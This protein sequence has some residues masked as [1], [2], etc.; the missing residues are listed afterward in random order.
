LKE[1]WGLGGKGHGGVLLRKQ[2]HNVKPT[3]TPVGKGGI[4]TGNRPQGEEFGDTS[5]KKRHVHVEGKKTSTHTSA[6]QLQVTPLGVSPH[7]KKRT[8]DDKGGEE[9]KAG[10]LGRVIL[11]PLGLSVQRKF[12][13]T[14]G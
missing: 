14:G 5:L 2:K 1:G 9:E 7:H 4:G 12:K 13:L 11:K 6:G 3:A 10:A 8:R